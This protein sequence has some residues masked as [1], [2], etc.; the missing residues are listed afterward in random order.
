MDC[1]SKDGT[2]YVQA[3]HIKHRKKTILCLKM[4]IAVQKELGKAKGTRK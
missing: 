1:G 2:V 3:C 4:L